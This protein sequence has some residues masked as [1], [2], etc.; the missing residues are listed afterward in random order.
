MCVLCVFVLMGGGGGGESKLRE[1][2]IFNIGR[3]LNNPQKREVVKNLL[4]DWKGDVVCL[5]ETKLAAVDLVTIRSIWGNMYA[6]WE[7]LNTVN[8]EGGSFCCGIRESW[9]N[10]IVTLVPS[11]F[12]AS[13]KVWM[14]TLFGP[15]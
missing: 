13:G 14:T 9:K 4:R 12:P 11:L 15:A 2:C 7:V 10:L 5:Q 6:G 3:G 1:E 8:S